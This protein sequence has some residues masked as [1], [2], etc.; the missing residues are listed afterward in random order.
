MPTLSYTQPDFPGVPPLP[1]PIPN[2]N[3]SD[4]DNTTTTTSTTISRGK[5]LSVGATVG[6]GI[7]IAA[8][9]I[10][11]AIGAWIFVR[12]RRRAWEVKRRALPQPK[13]LGDNPEI[14]IA[15]RV[16]DEESDDGSVGKE[17]RVWAEYGVAERAELGTARTV[18]VREGGVQVQELRAEREVG[19]MDGQRGVEVGGSA[20]F[21]V[22]LEGSAVEGME[23]EGTKTDGT[24]VEGGESVDASASEERRG[25]SRAVQ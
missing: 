19:E 24:K 1:P 9:V 18:E 14:E 17:M 10:L 16:R 13:V 5:N 4:S 21:A 11:A 6:I 2:P 23:V 12:R 25:E 3:D 8:F 22:E 15:K 20:G 7:G